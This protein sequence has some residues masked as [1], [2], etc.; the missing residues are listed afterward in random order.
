MSLCG[1]SKFCVMLMLILI[2]DDFSHLYI[3]T[4]Q[5]KTVSIFSPHFNLKFTFTCDNLKKF[6]CILPKFVMR[7]TSDPFSGKFNTD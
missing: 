2:D 7:V 4:E 5:I 3:A 6:P 1:I